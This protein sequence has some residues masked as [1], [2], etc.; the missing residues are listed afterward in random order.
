MSERILRNA[1]V[2]TPD[3]CFV[4]NVLIRNGVVGEVARGATG[5]LGAEDLEGDY[6]MPG[7]VELHTDNLEKHMLPRPGVHWDP[8]SA[9]V[10]HDAQC[11]SAGITTVFDAVTIGSRDQESIRARMQ[12]TAI[13]SMERCR[14][15]GVLRVDH[16][17]HLRCE[18]AAADILSV[19]ERHIDRADL[20]LISV[21]DHTAG[22]RQWRDLAK[23]RQ[24]M[25]RNGRYT[26]ESFRDMLA[27]QREGHEAWAAGHRRTVV[28]AA[29]ARA[30]PLASH[31]DTEIEHVSEASAEG[32]TMSEFPT[33]VDAAAAA[34]AAGMDIV[35]GAPNLVQGGSHSGNVSA[36]ELAERGLLD[37]LSSDYV[38]TSL[39]MSVFSLH[40]SMGWS[41]PRAVAAVSR[42]PARAVGLLDR[43][44]I[45]PGRRADLIRVR[46]RARQGVVMGTWVKGARV[47]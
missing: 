42:T 15:D 23:Y 1:R 14:D 13:D 22:Q 21:M 40:H 31:D 41:L 20:R 27:S 4:G 37:I 6:L 35:M 26:D 2:V 16:L 8:C 45:S 47:A 11:A 3:E 28:K 43:G 7:L 44:E 30:I 5:C 9:T 34:R 36:A 39:M 17:L 46:A 12:E 33:T 25:E 32:I 29:R 10:V 24:Y 18:V 38:P 19:F